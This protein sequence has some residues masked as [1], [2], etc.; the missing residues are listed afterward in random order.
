MTGYE[1]CIRDGLFSCAKPAG[2]PWSAD[3]RSTF[4]IVPI[5]LCPMPDDFSVEIE[6]GVV[7]MASQ[8]DALLVEVDHG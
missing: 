3:D 6:P 5:E 7:V 8:I 2:W 4:R 1:C